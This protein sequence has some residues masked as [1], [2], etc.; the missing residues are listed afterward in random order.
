MSRLDLHIEQKIAQ[1]DCIRLAAQWLAD[2]RGVIAEFGLGSGRSYSHLREHFPAHDVFCFDRLDK[3]HPDSRPPASRLYLGEFAEV[4]A[5]PAVQARF[6]GQV[7]LLH[8]DIGSG[9]PQ[10]AVLP[11]QVMAAVSP[12]LRP[13][14]V[15]LSD[16]DLTLEPTWCLD[17]IDLRGRV[18][19]AERY[20]VYRRRPGAAPGDAPRG[21]E[22]RR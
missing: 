21:Q 15:V 11:E 19:H 17:P 22:E 16:L 14:A 10:D 9:G 7:I 13:G 18:P 2:A 8:L 6:H 12:W 4:L 5:D 3:S 1:R 20:H